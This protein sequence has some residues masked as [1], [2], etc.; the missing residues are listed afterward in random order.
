MAELYTVASLWIGP[1]LSWMEQICLQSFVKHGHRTILYTYDPVMGVPEGVEQHDAREIMPESTIIYHKLTGSPA[2]HSDIFRLRLLS[3]TDYLWIDTDALCVKPFEK[4]DNGFFFGWGNEKQPLLFTGILGLPKDSKTLLAMMRLT[5]DE[6]PVPPW[7]PEEQQQ[8]LQ[9]RKDADNGLHVSEMQWGVLGPEAI[10]YFAKQTG[11]AAHALPGEVLYPVPFGR[12]NWFYWPRRLDRVYDY[13]KPETLSVHFFGRRMRKVLLNTEG[14]PL[15]GSYLA[16]LVEEY[17]VDPKKTAHLF[18]KGEPVAKKPA[19]ISL[20][21]DESYR[22]LLSSEKWHE[23]LKSLNAHLANALK[24][25]GAPTELNG[26]LFYEHK[27]AD[28]ELNEL[29]ARFD[30]KRRNLFTLAK[31]CD[32]MFEVGVNGGHS[33][34]LA[35]SAN[36]N[37]R[38]T[39]VDICKQVEPSWA[40]VDVYVPAAFDW[41]S[42]AFPGR[43]E[44]ITG[45]SLVELPRYTDEHPDEQVDL[46][47]LDGAKDTHLREFLALKPLMREGSFLLQD[48]TNTKPVRL[49][50]QQIQMLGLA[51]KAD[52]EQRGL[53]EIPGHKILIVQ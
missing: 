21:C 47:H 45:N 25:V 44:F 16:T 6:Y 17:G 39:G 4:P 14:Q 37:L 41:L 27:D 51:N 49:S 52:T 20:P 22:A 53:A 9:T 31:Q 33:L 3:Q 13:I 48:D 10:D 23:N 5:V 40:R 42:K 30:A 50:M 19:H 35:L 2:F 12:A 24:E 28:F 18:K 15:E 1:E 7:L 8:E 36:P 32:H 34:F 38:V 46:L 43:C 11:E 29:T 26:N